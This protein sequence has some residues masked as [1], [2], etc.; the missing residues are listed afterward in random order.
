MII[1]VNRMYS[2]HVAAEEEMQAWQAHWTRHY[3]ILQ[4]QEAALHDHLSSL[5]YDPQQLQ[6]YS[7]SDEALEGQLTAREKVAKAA[8]DLELNSA[9]TESKKKKSTTEGETSQ[10]DGQQSSSAA[11][12]WA[13]P[14]RPALKSKKVK[15]QWEEAVVE[16]DTE[17]RLP[18][19][20]AQALQDPIVLQYQDRDIY[21]DIDPSRYPE[22]FCDVTP[23]TV[24]KA[25]FYAR[26]CDT[27]L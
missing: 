17:Q 8:A 5:G 27:V 26:Y 20:T 2:I 25:Y 6:S 10:M 22:S 19:L 23:I 11:P 18:A 13:T 14:K 24:I 3:D 15:V 7:L 16:M 21:A 12:L 1:C 9:P 4:T